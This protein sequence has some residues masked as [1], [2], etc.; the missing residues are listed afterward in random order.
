MKKKALAKLGTAFLFTVLS[1]ISVA[2]TVKLTSLE[3]PPYSGQDLPNQGASIAVAKAAF[4]AM[5][6]TLEVDF[7]PWSRAVALA[8]G[9]HSYVGY[10]P[11]YLYE[12][13]DFV[14]SDPMGKGPLGFVEQSSNSIQWESLD[15][16]KNYQI[17]V[18]QD[19]VN[20][21]E[22]DAMIAS[23]EIDASSVTSDAQ[24]VLKV[25]AGRVDLAVVDSNV[26]DF[27]LA[28][29]SRVSNVKGKVQMNDKLLVTKDLYIAFKNSPAGQKWKKVFDEGLKK[30][31]VQS[32]M[33]SNM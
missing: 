14:F 8:K 16:L 1:S 24:N 33:S 21:A 2:E 18:V 7:F 29:D 26:L 22:L 4:D 3:W 11:E 5:G 31:D 23:G 32:I 27:L 25:A 10:F 15:D 12:S 6:H 17:G 20:T 9:D 13:Q 30:I 19:Y 28:N